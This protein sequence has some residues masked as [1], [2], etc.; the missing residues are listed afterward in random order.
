MSIK[1]ALKDVVTALGGTPTA[2]TVPGLLEQIAKLK[3]PLFGLTVTANIAA[4]E[5]L[6][7]KTIGDLQEHVFVKDGV[8]Y[9][10]V[11]YVNDYEGFSSLEA[12][13]SG[14]YLVLKAE[15]PGVEDVTITFT[16]TKTPVTLDSDGIIIYRVTKASK[17]IVFTASKVGCPTV[18]RTFRL[19]GVKFDPV[20]EE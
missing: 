4:D 19:K 18:T 13:Q 15:V 14:H 5:D 17:P 11:K 10:K 16:G 8:I 2:N 9:G 6:L 1:A 12:E 3:D 7:G 20:V